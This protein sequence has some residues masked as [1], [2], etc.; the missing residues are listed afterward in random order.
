[1]KCESFEQLAKLPPLNDGIDV[2]DAFQEL[3][4]RRCEE[5][6]KSNPDNAEFSSSFKMGWYKAEL[7]YYISKADPD[8]VDR[9]LKRYKE[10][11]K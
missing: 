3:V 2:V 5:W 10:I 6:I 4:D 8:I 9:S 7:A 11:N 1:M